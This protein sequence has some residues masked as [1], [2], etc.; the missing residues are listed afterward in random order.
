MFSAKLEVGERH[1]QVWAPWKGSRLRFPSTVTICYFV[2]NKLSLSP[3]P[4]LRG[5]L[6]WKWGNGVPLRPITLQPLRLNLSNGP[7][8][9]MMLDASTAC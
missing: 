3:F 8:K 6:Y 7:L 1:V 5:T 4:S 9:A 2:A